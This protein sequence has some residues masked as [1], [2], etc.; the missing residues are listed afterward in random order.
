MNWLKQLFCRH[1]YI[2]TDMGSCTTKCE[3][4]KCGKIEIR[5]LADMQV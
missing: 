3:C 5:S 2:Y 4:K 1:N